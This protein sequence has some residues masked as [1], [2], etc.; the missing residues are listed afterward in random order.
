MEQ[1]QKQIKVGDYVRVKDLTPDA[2]DAMAGDLYFNPRMRVYSGQKFKVTAVRNDDGNVRLDGNNWTWHPSWLELTD[3]PTSIL[4]RVRNH[5][6]ARIYSRV[7]G[8][9]I[10]EDIRDGVYPIIVKTLN[11]R[12]VSF[13]ADGYECDECRAT[14]GEPQLLPAKDETDWSKW[15]RDAPWWPVQ[16][17]VYYFITTVF[18]VKSDQNNSARIDNERINAGNCFRTR[19]AAEKVLKEMREIL[20]TAPRE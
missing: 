20:K 10:I 17:E 18:G 7:H 3:E 2:A 4:D 13:T 16:K 1:E 15:N 6:G 9:V 8:H 12:E 11:G 14:G 19:E 5:I